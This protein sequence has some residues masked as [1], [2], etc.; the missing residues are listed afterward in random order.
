MILKCNYL[1][2][3]SIYFLFKSYIYTT[4]ALFCWMLLD[5]LDCRFSTIQLAPS[6]K[7]GKKCGLLDVLDVLQQ[8][9]LYSK[10]A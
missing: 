1:L 5:V 10:F 7:N 3:S 8:Y 4:M 6:N 2:Y 9:F